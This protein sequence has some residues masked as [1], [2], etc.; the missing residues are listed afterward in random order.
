MIKRHEITGPSCLTSA[1]DDEPLFVLR[2]NDELASGLV[3][4]WAEQY[5]KSKGDPRHALVGNPVVATDQQW[6][7]YQEALRLADAMD[8][9]RATKESRT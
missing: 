2:A 6:A 7:K 9:W 8:V 3:R 5:I 4:S 1:A